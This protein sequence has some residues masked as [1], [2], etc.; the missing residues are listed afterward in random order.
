MKRAAEIFV[1]TGLAALIHV[2]LF[3]RLPDS[4]AQASGSGG[5]ELLSL[6]AV[7]PTA[8]AMVERWQRQPEAQQQAE[9]E[10]PPPA[11]DHPAL[12]V[13]QFELA[14]APRAQVLI[15]VTAP[16]VG[17]IPVAD[18]ATAALPPP[19]LIPEPEPEPQPAPKP[20]PPKP[21][22]KPAPPKPRAEPAA[23]AD[24][25]QQEDGQA[26]QNF[27]GRSKQ[28]AAGAGGGQQ[29]GADG[30]SQASTGNA[31]QQKRLK[32]VW[33]SKIR[34]RVARGQRYPA[35]QTQNARVVVKLTVARDGR[36]LGAKI[37]ESSGIAAF[38]SAAMAAVKR[39]GRFPKAPKKLQISQISFSLPMSFDR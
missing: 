28:R 8:A 29:A 15:P 3:A 12:A 10:A 21:E 31:K 24:P 1:F 39:V 20:A 17:K 35:G 11:A 6:Q 5:E 14:E 37:V 7:N 27:P 19:D 2:G 18:T 9:V 13:P 36:L 34:A 30:A 25:A 26:A 22:P 4:G 23:K 16:A 38:D 32:S 33:G